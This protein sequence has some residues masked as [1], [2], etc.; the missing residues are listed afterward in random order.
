MS[1][2]TKAIYADLQYSRMLFISFYVLT[3]S[4]PE[5]VKW[6]FVGLSAVSAFYSV[7]TFNEANEQ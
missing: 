7:K 3:Q 2:E 4:V 5:W 1:K 6:L